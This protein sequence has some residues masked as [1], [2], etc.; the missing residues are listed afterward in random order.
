MAWV[1]ICLNW[2]FSNYFSGICQLKWP[3]KGFSLIFRNCSIFFLSVT[4]F[5]I[6]QIVC[7]IKHTLVTHYFYDSSALNFF[8]FFFFCEN[9][10]CQKMPRFQ[11]VSKTFVSAFYCTALNFVL[12]I[13]IF[14]SWFLNFNGTLVISSLPVQNR[15]NRKE[16]QFERAGLRI[17]PAILSSTLAARSWWVIQ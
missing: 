12:P 11:I 2:K 16:W 3:W 9:T 7:K 4:S 5:Y 17:F 1:Q 14:R 10:A 6:L 13:Q 15:L 8:F